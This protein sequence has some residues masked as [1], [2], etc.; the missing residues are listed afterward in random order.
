MLN[1][2]VRRLSKVKD[3]IRYM[4]KLLSVMNEILGKTIA[5]TCTFNGT[6]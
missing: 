3:I 1:A 2:Y 6:N 4:D 5:F